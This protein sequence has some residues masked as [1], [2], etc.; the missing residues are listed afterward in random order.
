[1]TDLAAQLSNMTDAELRKWLDNNV[2]HHINLGGFA[3]VEIGIDI[4]MSDDDEDLL[5]VRLQQ[6]VKNCH[7]KQFVSK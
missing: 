4:D 5:F 1:M 6:Y 7:M 3:Y 2:K